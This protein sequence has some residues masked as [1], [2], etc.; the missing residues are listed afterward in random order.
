M[1]LESSIVLGN[2]EFV[3]KDHSG[4][5][6]CS[7]PLPEAEADEKGQVP[8]RH[9]PTTVGQNARCTQNARKD[10]DHESCDCR[11]PGVEDHEE[12]GQLQPARCSPVVAEEVMKTI[13]L[14]TQGVTVDA[15]P[16]TEHTTRRRRPVLGPSTETFME[17]H[18][19]EKL[20]GNLHPQ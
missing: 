5:E 12:R 15:L 18:T 16:G 6:N 20:R 7:N 8:R 1:L 11:C 4:L 9:R 13:C 19:T 14:A 2:A 10:T 3:Q 17:R